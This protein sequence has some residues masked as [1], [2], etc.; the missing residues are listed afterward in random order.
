MYFLDHLLQKLKQCYIGDSV[1]LFLPFL[2]VCAQL[3]SSKLEDT[4]L[5]EKSC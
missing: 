3:R 5:T 4:I 2:P 1:R